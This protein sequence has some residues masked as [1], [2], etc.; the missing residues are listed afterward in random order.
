M[1]RRLLQSGTAAVVFAIVLAGAG[2]VVTA[3]RTAQQKSYPIFTQ[4]D[5]VKFMKTVGQNF[6]AVNASV[7]SGDFESAKSQ[8]TRSREQLAWTVTFWRDRGK[9]DALK[10]LKDTLGTMDALDEAL[11]AEQINAERVNAAVKQ[12]NTSCEACH[13]QYR[14]YNAATRSYGFKAGSIP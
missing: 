14:E 4:D 3:Q 1:Y 13:A 2:A 11:S 7:G 6:G 9:A 8:L 10:L 5:F 12:V